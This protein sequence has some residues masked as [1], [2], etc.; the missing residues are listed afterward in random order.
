MVPTPVDVVSTPVDVT[1][2]N[3][4]MFNVNA[5][6]GWRDEANVVHR[7]GWRVR[8]GC[9]KL[10]DFITGSL[11][12]PPG[13]PFDMRENAKQIDLNKETLIPINGFP[14]EEMP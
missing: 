3:C 8:G 12:R 9:Y 13:R 5:P 6:D 10:C 2:M 4:L 14:E 1:C 7:V 11:D